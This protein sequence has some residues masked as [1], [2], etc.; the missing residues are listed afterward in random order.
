MTLYPITVFRESFSKTATASWIVPGV[1][2]NLFAVQDGHSKEVGTATVSEAG[3]I[4]V[5]RPVQ[6]THDQDLP[7][8]TGT[9]LVVIC[10]VT[11]TYSVKNFIY[12]Y[13][14][15]TNYEVPKTLGDIFSSFPYAWD[16]QA[17]LPVT[18]GSGSNKAQPS[19]TQTSENEFAVM[20]DPQAGVESRQSAAGFSEFQAIRTA[21]ITDDVVQIE[22][23][24]CSLKLVD[25]SLFVV[26]ISRTTLAKIST[27]QLTRLRTFLTLQE[28]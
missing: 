1:P 27:E 24:Q 2:V 14:F 9:D 5:R 8:N 22:D 18:A 4:S 15:I 20:E 17:M 7:H 28:M 23:Q 6:G 13:T 16:A 26:Y 12:R 3:A 21:I 25:T 10:S 19:E 11:I